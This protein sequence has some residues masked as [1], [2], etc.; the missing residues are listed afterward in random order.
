MMRTTFMLFNRP[1]QIMRLSTPTA[2]EPSKIH[3][4][5][6]DYLL[7][8]DQVST[9]RRSSP[10]VGPLC[11]KHLQPEQTGTKLAFYK[12]TVG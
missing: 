2:E 6:V 9:S 5:T 12:V 7:L 8:H 10:H 11:I 3:G 1:V 4:S